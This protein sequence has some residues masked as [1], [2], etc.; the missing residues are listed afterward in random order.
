MSV[1]ETCVKNI[2]RGIHSIK[3]GKSPSEANVGPFL[4]RLKSINDGL[5]E[6][7]MKKYKDVVENFNQ[8]KK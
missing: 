3:K 2:E 4:N 5:Y 6:D 8:N 7:L 1:E